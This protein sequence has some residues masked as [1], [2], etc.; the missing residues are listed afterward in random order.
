M[1]LWT[2]RPYLPSIVLGS[3]LAFFSTS[4]FGQEPTPRHADDAATPSGPAATAPA[5]A[6]TAP[7]APHALDPPPAP[8]ETEAPPRPQAPKPA[9]YS[10]PF[11]LRPVVAATVVRS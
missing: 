8:D 6:T 11:Q 1:P 9:P 10:L 2:A 4:A 7:A 5:P 3:S